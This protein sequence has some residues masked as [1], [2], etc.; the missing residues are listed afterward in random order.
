MDYYFTIFT[1]VIVLG[2]LSNTQG[3]HQKLNKYPRSFS[4]VQESSWG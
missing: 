1:S 2:V 3:L 4:K